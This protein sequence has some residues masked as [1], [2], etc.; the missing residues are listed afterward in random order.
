MGQMVFS[1]DPVA[2]IR[3]C[4]RPAEAKEERDEGG[5][6]PRTPEGAT[7][8]TG[9]TPDPDP[10]DIFFYLSCPRDLS[11]AQVLLASAP[12]EDI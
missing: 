9:G 6:A 4:V 5:E 7:K 2:C 10:R 1:T 8:T 3:K 12:I 11:K